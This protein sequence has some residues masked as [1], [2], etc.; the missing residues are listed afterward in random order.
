MCLFVLSR[1]RILLSPRMSFAVFLWPLLGCC[2]LGFQ[3]A[4]AELE[5][6]LM[7]HPEIA[8]STVIPVENDEAGEL[9]RAYVVLAEG[10]TLKEADVQDYV[11]SKVAPHKK[12]RGG[13]IFTDAIPKTAS[14][15]ILRRFVIRQDRETN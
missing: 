7:S 4:P 12:L 1:A 8:D 9:P 10:S 15:K 13:V 5:D 11:A 3:V 2:A 6:V 14:G